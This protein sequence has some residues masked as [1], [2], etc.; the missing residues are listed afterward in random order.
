MV[1][2]DGKGIHFDGPGGP[3]DFGEL[4]LEVGLVVLPLVPDWVAGVSISAIY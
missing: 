1:G 4:A 2:P 3:E